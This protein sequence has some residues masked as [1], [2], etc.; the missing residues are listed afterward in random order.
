MWWKQTRAEF[1][2]QHGEANR[3][4][5]KAIVDSGIVPGILAYSNDRP[6]GWCA[7]ESRKSYTAL[8]RSRTLARVD[9]KPVWAIPCFYVAKD[10]RGRGLMRDLLTASINWAATNGALIVEAYP[11]EP[12]IKRDSSLYTGVVSVFREAGFVEV[13][14]RSVRRPIMRKTIG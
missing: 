3:I 1:A 11:F 4:A 6:I 5:L 9:D 2:R 8:D 14:R 10:W 12:R 7:V 13:M